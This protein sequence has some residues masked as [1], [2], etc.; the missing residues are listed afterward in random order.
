MRT[1]EYLREFERGGN[2][3]RDINYE[4]QIASIDATALLASRKEHWP[5]WLQQ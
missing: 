4:G 3:L 5:L 2:S 1:V